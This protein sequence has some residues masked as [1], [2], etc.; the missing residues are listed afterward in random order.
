MEGLLRSNTFNSKSLCDV[1]NGWL[2]KRLGGQ[3]NPN[4]DFLLAYIECRG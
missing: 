2:E 3:D 1:Y 4:A